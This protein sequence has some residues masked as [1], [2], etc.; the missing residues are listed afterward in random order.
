MKMKMIR[1]Q[2]RDNDKGE[3]VQNTQAL[4]RSETEDKERS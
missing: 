2:G 1:V 3:N 4:C